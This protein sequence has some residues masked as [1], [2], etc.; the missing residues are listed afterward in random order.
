MGFRLARLNLTDE[1]MA[2][3]R[4]LNSATALAPRRRPRSVRPR[5][6]ARHLRDSARRR[7]LDSGVLRELARLPGTTGSMLLEA[8]ATV[9]RT[10]FPPDFERGWSRFRGKRWVFDGFDLVMQ[11]ELSPSREN[12]VT[13]GSERDALGRPR[14]RLD[15]RWTELSRRTAARV[16]QVLA[17]AF[18]DAGIGDVRTPPEGEL[19]IWGD[20]GHDTH[21]QMGATRM[22]VSP[23]GGVVDPDCRVHGLE[24]LFVAGSSVFPVGGYANPTLTIVALSLRLAD[25]IERALGSSHSRPDSS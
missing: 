4:V 12:R 8:A 14:A 13:L 25:H 19:H 3:E 24:N 23:A 21:H 17:T 16:P 11:M 18:A 9:G 5:L 15:V 22:S 10:P 6:V 1:A 7:R 20:T 2:D